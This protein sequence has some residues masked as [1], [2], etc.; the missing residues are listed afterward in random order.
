MDNNQVYLDIARSLVEGL[1]HDAE[2]GLGALSEADAA[3]C[4]I[5]ATLKFILDASG[6]F[7]M[8]AEAMLEIADLGAEM[9]VTLVGEAVGAPI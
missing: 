7:E 4:V 6:G 5:A 9:E 8:F 1:A 2:V 3:V